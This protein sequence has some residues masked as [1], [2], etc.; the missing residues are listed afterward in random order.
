MTVSV[1]LGPALT[2][3]RARVLVGVLLG[4]DI[5][6]SPSRVLRPS[7]LPQNPFSLCDLAHTSG[8]G[9]ADITCMQGWIVLALLSYQSC[10]CR[11]GDQRVQ[12]PGVGPAPTKSLCCVPKMYSLQ[13][14]GCY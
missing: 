2:L 12:R 4:S 3:R 14:K 10:T 7:N 13:R 6:I 11:V 9:V 1:R 8:P 5:N